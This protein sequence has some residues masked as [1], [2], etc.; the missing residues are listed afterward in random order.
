[1]QVTL[2]VMCYNQEQFILDTLRGDFAQ[3]YDGLT[4]LISDDHSPDGT[5]EVIRNFLNGY[6]GPHNV[7][8]NR[9]AP[10][11]GL[12]DHVNHLFTLAKG[13][14]L[15]IYN[16]G[17]DISEPHRVSR[18][19]SEFQAHNP[20]LIHT[21]VLDM[22]EDGRLWGR[23][24][25]RQ[26][27]KKVM[28]FDLAHAAKVNSSC[29]GATCAWSPEL[30][31]IFGPIT[32]KNAIEDRVFYFRSRLMNRTL[33]LDEKLLRYRRGVG[34]TAKKAGDTGYDR[35]YLI[36]D[37]ASYRQRLADTRCVAP[38]RGD[39]IAALEHKIAKSERALE[40]LAG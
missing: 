11:L 27:A 30:I 8:L 38:E 39:I 19:A 12:I 40:A 35:R 4:I 28:D 7:I 23:Q 15:L 22:H 37:I 34:L 2:A 21:D 25:E 3:D 5:Y 10:N 17:D 16:A 20:L 33:Y 13:S 32:E 18:L 24:R 14:D 29:L 31:D 36:M 6:N 9:N 1:M 26:R